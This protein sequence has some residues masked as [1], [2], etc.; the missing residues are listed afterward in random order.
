MAMMRIYKR[1]NGYH[2][3]D[4]IRKQLLRSEN[5]VG[6]ENSESAGRITFKMA[7]K[8]CRFNDYRLDAR[9]INE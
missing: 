1:K 6:S 9:K 8:Y 5:L 3:F 2:S 4:K 7:E